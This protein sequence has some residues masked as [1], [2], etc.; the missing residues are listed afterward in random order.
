M[1]SVSHHRG[2]TSGSYPVIAKRNET[3]TVVYMIVVP[4]AERS[5][6]RAERRYKCCFYDHCSHRGGDRFSITS[7]SAK[8]IEKI[9]VVV[10]NAMFILRRREV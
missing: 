6:L 10:Y 1:N 3:T 7:V 9:R 2:V 5:S 8:S 4:T